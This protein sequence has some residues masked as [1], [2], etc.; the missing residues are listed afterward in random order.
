MDKRPRASTAN[1]RRIRPAHL[2]LD[3]AHRPELRRKPAFV[4]IHSPL[5]G[6]A[7]WSLVAHELQRHGHEAVV[8]SLR[9]I[10]SAPEPQW[11]YALSAVRAATVGIG[12][13]AILI[14]HSGAGA[15]L[16]AIE[17]ALPHEVAALIF[18]DASLPPESGSAPLAPARFLDQ[19]RALA[20]DGTLPR[21]SWF[22][23][24]IAPELIAEEPLRTVLTEECPRVPL[25]Y[26]QD[27][28]P[29]PKHWTRRRCAYLRLSDT[30]H[31]ESIP[32]AR[33][34]GWPVAAIRGAHHLS[35]VTDPEAVTAILLDL[36]RELYP[37]LQ[38]TPAR[39]AL[40]KRML[41]TAPQSK[42]S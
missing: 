38:T 29:M 23:H 6:P 20:S 42:A 11:R 2:R 14:G 27:R 3:P 9:G 30:A 35:I 1:N 5:L 32:Q 36:A 10:A 28:V 8:P 26:F 17:R 12:S 31:P 18:V 13:P 7:S 15:L 39:R 24:E 25:S 19:L 16:P 37:K 41:M 34:H 33:S 21:A 4:L 22:R 40:A